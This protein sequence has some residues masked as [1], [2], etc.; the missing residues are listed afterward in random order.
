LYRRR[1]ITK[2][3]RR[4]HRCVCEQP[5]RSKIINFIPNFKF[6]EEG[7]RLEGFRPHEKNQRLSVWKKPSIDKSGKF[8][9]L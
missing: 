9:M 5:K 2:V 4:Q 1:G 7:V 3:D 8:D 6:T